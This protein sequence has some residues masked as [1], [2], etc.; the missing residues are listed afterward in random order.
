MKFPLQKIKLKDGELVLRTASLRDA[1]ALNKI[2]QE[3]GVNDF[4]LLIP[5]VSVASAVK[6]IKELNKSKKNAWIVCESNGEV[7]GS[8]DLRFD[9]GRMSH[10]SGF[11]ISFTK[12]AHGTGLAAL[13]LSKAFAFAKRKGI[14]LISS[15]VINANK[16][17]RVFYKKLGFKEVGVLKK[18]FKTGG[19]YLD[20]V[21]IVKK[22]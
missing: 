7:V 2:I 8:V 18:H 1:R 15:S 20:V 5:P 4:L 16:R 21:L 12:K 22:L 3:Q 10:V 6:R 13:T 14:E 11:G 17:A 19:K 9:K